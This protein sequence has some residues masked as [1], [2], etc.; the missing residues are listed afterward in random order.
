M[1]W[2]GW[3]ISHLMFLFGK[4]EYLEINEFFRRFESHQLETVWAHPNFECSG[5]GLLCKQ[6]L[7]G[8][9]CGGVSRLPLH[10]RLTVVSIDS[11]ASVWLNAS[12]TLIGMELSYVISALHDYFIELEEPH[13]FRHRSAQ[14]QFHQFTQ[15]A[16]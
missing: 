2:I 12:N 15:I 9:R 5:W 1:N 7:K 6:R 4:L 16:I 3:L 8:E 11:M 10:W 13:V 14:I